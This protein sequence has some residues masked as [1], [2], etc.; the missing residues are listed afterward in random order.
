MKKYIYFV[1]FGVNNCFGNTDFETT[2]EIKS[3]KDIRYIENQL[4]QE[5]DSKIVL[6]GYE[7]LRIEE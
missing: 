7:L 5:M 1:S 2:E 3:L 4:N 6:L